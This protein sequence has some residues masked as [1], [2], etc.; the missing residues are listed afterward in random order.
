MARLSH[1]TFA[2]PA[3]SSTTRIFLDM[4]L[5]SNRR[6]QPLV[7]N[8]RIQRLFP[9]TSNISPRSVERERRK[10]VLFDL[11]LDEL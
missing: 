6:Y 5:D 11:P 10:K 9:G 3:S 1:S 4:G 8:L 7:G 2:M